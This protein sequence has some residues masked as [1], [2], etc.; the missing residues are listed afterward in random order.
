MSYSS[1]SSSDESTY[2]PPFSYKDHPD[3]SD[4]EPVPL[5]PSDDVP[6]S[7]HRSDSYTELFS[8]F[9]AFAKSGETSNRA[10]KISEDVIKEYPAHY[11]AWWNKF[12]ILEQHGFDFEKEDRIL[13][14]ILL[15]SPKSYQAW[16]FKQWLYDH[17]TEFHDAIPFLEMAT[18]FDAKNFHMWSFALWYAKRWNRERDVYELAK[19]LCIED[20]RNNSAWNARKILGDQIGVSPANEFE[21]AVKTLRI[22]G[23]NE[24]AVN[25]ALAMV[26][27]DN[28][29]IDKAHD[30]GEELVEKNPDNMFGYLI[31]LFVLEFKNKQAEADISKERA[32][33]CDDLIRVDPIRKPYYT[34]LKEGRIQY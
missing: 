16:Y 8:Y 11:T 13:T 5:S 22:V 9:N 2:D 4:T 27:K 33:I 3:F 7:I 34:L 32:I 21:E 23:K 26:K 29:L 18:Q 10:L 19:R 31:R 15:Q 17:I 24:A 30:L 25:F 20:F 28:S 6:Y 1:E 12:R 14:D